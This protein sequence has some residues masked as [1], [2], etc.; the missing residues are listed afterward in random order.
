MNIRQIL[1]TLYL[2]AFVLGAAQAD[3][4]ELQPLVSGMYTN[5]NGVNS[6][7][8]QV[9]AGWRGQLYGSETWGTGIWGLADANTVLGLGAS[10]PAVVVTYTGVLDQ[11]HWADKVYLDT[12]APTWGPQQLVPFLSDDPSQYQDNYAVSFTG[13]ISITSPGLYNFGVLFDDGFM[14]NLHGQG[15]TLNLI[16][17]GLNPRERLGFDQDLQLGAGLYGFDL[18]AYERLEAGVINL[19]WSQPGGDWT[20]IPEDHL[21]TT[22]VPEPS[23]MLLL[24]AGLGLLG[25]LPRVRSAMK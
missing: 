8:V 4:V 21:F 20:T 3:P 19:S 25:L 13:Y 18:V 23:N 17:D 12:W 7:W 9:D 16:R 22:V 2:A 5:G 14:F 1:G 6:Q 15:L 10:N 24:L 11:I